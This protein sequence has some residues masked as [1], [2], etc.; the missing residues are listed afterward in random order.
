[1][2]LQIY[3][4]LFV[5][6]W[7]FVLVVTL[8]DIRWAVH[9]RD[10]AALWEANPLMRWVMTHYG[11]WVAG[12]VRLAT[13]L[14]ALSLMP[15]APRR[16]QVTATLTLTSIHVYLAYTYVLIV[17]DQLPASQALLLRVSS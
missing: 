10:T 4:S 16:S 5:A 15:M 6:A 9:Y 3:R 11:V 17:F 8:F 1:M 7:L 12:V 14:F 13:V 2:S